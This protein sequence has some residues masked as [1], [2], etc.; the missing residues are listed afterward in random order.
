MLSR[1]DD[2]KIFW[3]EVLFLDFVEFLQTKSH[4][5]FT[6]FLSIDILS[7]ITFIICMNDKFNIMTLKHSPNYCI[8]IFYTFLYFNG[9]VVDASSDTVSTIK[10]LD[11]FLYFL[12][13]KLISFQ[14]IAVINPTKVH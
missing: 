8:M 5:L 11:I 14:Y 1:N 4:F 9:R 2:D 7:I 13:R 12:N 6:V 10:M 3:K